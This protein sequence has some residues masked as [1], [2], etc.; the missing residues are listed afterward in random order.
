M[1]GDVRSDA[2]PAI[3]G[4][5][6]GDT[7]EGELGYMSTVTKKIATI[8]PSKSV[9]TWRWSWE[10]DGDTCPKAAPG[11]VYG[12]RKEAQEAIDECERLYDNGV[13]RHT[14]PSGETCH[15]KIFRVA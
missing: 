14:S 1:R 11:R 9:Y 3:Q 12:S 5:D 10:Y 4:Q 15:R 8:H 13:S 7:R 6:A 2:A